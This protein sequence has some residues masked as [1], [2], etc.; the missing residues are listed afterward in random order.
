MQN[1]IFE[2]FKK[3]SADARYQ[4]RGILDDDWVTIIRKEFEVPADRIMTKSLLN[5]AMAS[6]CISSNCC[7]VNGHGIFHG[8]WTP[9]F[10]PNGEPNKSKVKCYFVMEPSDMP[11]RNDNWYGTVKHVCISGRFA[12]L[13]EDE[14]K[15]FAEKLHKEKAEKPMD[16]GDTEAGKKRGVTPEKDDETRKK[17]PRIGEDKTIP[18][19]I[20]TSGFT[21]AVLDE[22]IDKVCEFRDNGTNPCVKLQTLAHLIMKACG[23]DDDGAIALKWLDCREEPRTYT[24]RYVPI[25]TSKKPNPNQPLE[26]CATPRA[27]KKKAKVL[28]EI[29]HHYYG[30]QKKAVL[31]QLAELEGFVLVDQESLELSAQK[32]LALCEWVGMMGNGILRLDQFFCISLPKQMKLFPSNLYKVM[33]VLEKKD[34][35]DLIIQKVGLFTNNT[36]YGT[37]L[38][39]HRSVLGE[40]TKRSSNGRHKKEKVSTVTK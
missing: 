30:F 29:V 2:A 32:I 8:E 1:A 7:E 3:A 5:K 13:T 37:S 24:S 33:N 35:M 16:K 20:D 12:T 25:P 19:E 17:R 27:T 22:M 23:E 14:K 18:M 39:H 36:K 26:K 28:S 15:S 4:K 10:L 38:W 34:D 40:D 31:E 21:A 6:N 11:P 9:D